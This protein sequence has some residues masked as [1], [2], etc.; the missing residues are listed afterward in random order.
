M[1]ID[2][3]SLVGIVT[4]ADIVKF[5]SELLKATINH[6]ESSL[7]LLVI[8]K[9]WLTAGFEYNAFSRYLSPSQSLQLLALAC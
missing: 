3:W 1:I 7:C 8:Q 2:T 6:L 5:E 9:R 4:R